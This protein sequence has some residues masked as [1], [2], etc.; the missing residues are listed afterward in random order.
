MSYY[1]LIH[2]HF[3]YCLRV[4]CSTTQSNIDKL[5]I[6]QKKSLRIISQ[7]KYNAHTL[8]LF[9]FHKILPFPDLIIFQNLLFMHSVDKEYIKV[10]FSDIFVKSRE[11]LTHN[12]P[13]RN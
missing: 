1:A 7:A 8:P 4:I 2:P 10:K 6:M 3:L 9:F 13:L 11:I 5:F 12:Y